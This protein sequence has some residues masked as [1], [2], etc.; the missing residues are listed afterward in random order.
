M[1]AIT[2]PPAD[3]YACA[4]V[5][6]AKK[7]QPWALALQQQSNAALANAVREQ[8]CEDDPLLQTQAVRFN[9]DLL[10]VIGSIQRSMTKSEKHAIAKEALSPL[11]RQ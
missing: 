1:D 11:C 2:P 6:D 5:S 9:S 7:L 10:G 4:P 8:F 3:V